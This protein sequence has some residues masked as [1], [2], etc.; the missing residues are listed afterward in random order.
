MRDREAPV[1][2]REEEPWK[3]PSCPAIDILTWL[4]I[5]I[6]KVSLG[7][8]LKG[9]QEP[10][11]CPRHPQAFEQQVIEAEGKIEGWIPEPGA[12]GI[13]EDRALRSDQNVLWADI[14]MN[15]R[16]LSWGGRLPKF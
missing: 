16:L 11:R 6:V 8:A 14:A 13:D 10:T 15:P 5:D 7:Q 9:R 1:D 4:P 12:F 2:P 3:Q